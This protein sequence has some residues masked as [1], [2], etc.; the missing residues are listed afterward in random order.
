MLKKKHAPPGLVQAPRRLTTLRWCPIWLR[1][2]SSLISA[3]CSLGVAPSVGG[4]KNF[5]N[6]CL[7]LRNELVTNPVPEHLLS[8]ISKQNLTH[9]ICV[10]IFNSHIKMVCE[11]RVL[12]SLYEEYLW[13]FWQPL[14]YSRLSCWYQK[15]TPASL[16][17]MPLAP[18]ASLLREKIYINVMHI[19]HILYVSAHKY[20]PSWRRSCGNSHFS[21]S[22]CSLSQCSSRGPTPWCRM[23]GRYSVLLFVVFGWDTIFVNKHKWK[24]LYEKLLLL[25]KNFRLS[26][27][28]H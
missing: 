19:S 1:I 24:G 22:Y 14:W 7:S 28:N 13:A 9:L 18:V 8:C 15:Q 4:V 17:R 11:T 16:C 5:I 3:L 26:K 2:F 21:A 20:V 25:R 23:I 27:L 12:Q 6:H 10:L